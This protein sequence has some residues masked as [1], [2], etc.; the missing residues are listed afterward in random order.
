MVAQT[1][2]PALRLAAAVRLHGS[3][4]RRASR[5]SEALPRKTATAPS[6]SAGAPQDRSDNK[7]AKDSNAPGRR[8]CHG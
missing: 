5:S 1:L 8:A 6:G 2:L 4:S 7:H 3:P